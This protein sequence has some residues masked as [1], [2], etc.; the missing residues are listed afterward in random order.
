MLKLTLV[1]ELGALLTS[2]VIQ[3]VAIDNVKCALIGMKCEYESSLVV[4]A[5]GVR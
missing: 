5:I 3:L 2:M 1:A 4:D